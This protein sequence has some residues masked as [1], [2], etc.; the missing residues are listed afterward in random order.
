M[1]YPT[2]LCSLLLV[3]FSAQAFAGAK[4]VGTDY[5]QEG[6]QSW[7][8][9][10]QYCGKCHN[11]I[12]WAGGVAFDIM[13]PSQVPS[14]PKV[15]EAAIKKLSGR[16]MPPPGNPQPPQKRIDHFVSW[17]QSYLD[18]VQAAG[19]DPL[20][21]HVS[22]Q[23]LDR[24]QYGDSVQ[25][26]LGLKVDVNDLLPPENEVGGFDNIAAALSMSP[27]FLDQYVRAAR[28]V[29]NL[30]VGKPTVGPSITFFPSPRTDQASYLSGLPLG[31]RG[32]M[33]FTYNFPADGEYKFTIKDLD[34]GLYTWAVETRSTVILLVDGKQVFRGSLGGLKDLE[35][36]DRDGP[37]GRA[38]IMARFANI[39]AYVKAGQ[40]QVVVTFIKRS[41]AESDDYVDTNAFFDGLRQSRLLGGVQVA[42][43]YGPTKLSMTASRRKIFVCEPRAPSEDRACAVKI[44]EHLA[45]LAF[46]RPVTQADLNVLMPFYENGARQGGFDEGINHVVAAI[47]ASPD[48]LYRAVMP[49]KNADDGKLHRLS[50]L[51]LAS[52][53]SFF[54][55]DQGPDQ[56]LLDAAIAGKLTD[57]KVLDVQTLRMLNDP[58]AKSLVTDFAFH[59]LDLDK[60]DSVVPDRQL[61]PSYT[62]QLETDFNTEARL[63]LGSIML[64]NQSVVGLLNANYTF[65]NEQLAKHYGIAGVHGTQFRR[66]VLKNPD[67]WGLLGKGAVLMETSYANRTSPVRRGAWVLD[68]L[69]GTPPAP[70]PPAV[71]MNLDIK[72]GQKAT[73]VRARLAL[74]RADPF[75]AQCHGVI[76]PYGLSLENFDVTGA[77]RT[78][79]HIANEPI[80][81]H[82]TLPNGVKVRGVNGLRRDLLSKPAQFVGAMTAKLMMYALARKLDY[83][84]MPQV[85][86]IVRAAR[87]D[88][89][90]FDSIVLGIVNSDDFRLQA[91]PKPAGPASLKVAS[92][93][94]PDGTPG[95]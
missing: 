67:R 4:A 59:W 84:D 2:L 25:G 8:M 74:H 62:P 26:L 3:G 77:W 13:K 11:T 63:F 48:F 61:F 83:F 27:S 79:D 39:P 90:R 42:G 78:Y 18:A 56:E 36:A 73:T 17:L 54:L 24:T 20:A 52:R 22:I 60:L 16:L 40:H 51:E 66:V 91:E 87:K 15:F 65:V 86:A 1:R 72:P 7:G 85:R 37:A 49:T 9:L 80:D 69:L 35:L 45:E 64:D 31:S 29:A 38:K 23:R 41:H 93:V 68:K 19:Q 53:L 33:A 81:A 76:D 92:N 57:P 6:H 10:K 50:N 75:C 14:N 58:R 12:D 21:G 30:A 28:V 47:L 46:R 94:N 55:W 88:D 43:P 95:R 44:T 34:V 71:N 89:Y 82:S 32:G 70:P 5:V